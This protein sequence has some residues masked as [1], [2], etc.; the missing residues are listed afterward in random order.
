MKSLIL[1]ALL[2]TTTLSQTTNVPDNLL[3]S[4]LYKANKA[5]VLMRAL[6][7]YKEQQEIARK[8]MS[9]SDSVEAN[10]RLALEQGDIAIESYKKISEI[11][12]Q[13]TKQ[14]DN[15]AFAG[16]MALG[17]YVLEYRE[18]KYVYSVF[19]ISYAYT[20]IFDAPFNIFRLNERI[21]L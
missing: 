9:A 3:D 17:S 18:P 10:L 21:G 6:K 1:F 2:L 12:Q 15:L 11:Y 7:S 16:L 20:L 19:L 13:R 14:A 4:L 5:N 8:F